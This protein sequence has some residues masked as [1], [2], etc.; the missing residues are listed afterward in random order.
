MCFVFVIGVS[1]YYFFT[2]RPAGEPV[3]SDTWATSTFSVEKPASFAE[4]ENGVFRAT[5]CN[6]SEVFYGASLIQQGD[7]PHGTWSST[8]QNPTSALKKNI[9]IYSNDEQQLILNFN[10]KR[11]S[12]IE[13][14]SDNPVRRGSNIGILLVGDIGLDYYNPDILQPRALWMD[15]WLDTNPELE[16]KHW[17]GT[18]SLEHDY[19]SGF[20]VKTMPE[21]GKEYEF[22]FRIDSY[23]R[24]ALNEW[25]GRANANFES[26]TLKM[27]QCYIEAA[28]SKA[29]IEVN[30]ISIRT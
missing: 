10:G 13:W 5:A 26:F 30:R 6:H 8:V 21:V 15:I 18:S 3:T 14:F 4:F 12:Q 9:T 22:S 25:N 2:S 23:I 1:S 7:N 24:D 17:I 20:P 29:S 28:A 19:H 16:A 11:T 27:V